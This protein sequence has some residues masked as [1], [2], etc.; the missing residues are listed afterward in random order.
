[1][2]TCRSQVARRVVKGRSP[3]LETGSYSIKQDAMFK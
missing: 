3:D 1:M 2:T